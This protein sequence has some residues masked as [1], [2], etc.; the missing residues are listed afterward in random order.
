M[1]ISYT[2]LQ[3]AISSAASNTTTA[4]GN[5]LNKGSTTTPAAF[6][7][8]FYTHNSV[9]YTKVQTLTTGTTLTHDYRDGSIVQITNQSTPSDIVLTN[10]QF[11]AV[12]SSKFVTIP[13]R[14]IFFA[15][16]SGS[17]P[18]ITS[19]NGVAVAA[20]H[21]PGAGTSHVDEDRVTVDYQIIIPNTGGADVYYTR[22][23]AL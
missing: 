1:T 16:G 13:F 5:K 21:V 4:V 9:D 7:G 6:P 23:L 12:S 11:S 3:A 2:A 15:S 20:N 14:L 18:Q 10:V 19:V 22:S 8:G 17:A